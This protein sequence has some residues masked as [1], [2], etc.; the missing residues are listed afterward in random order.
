MLPDLPS[1]KQ[2]IQCILDRYLH[3]AIHER[4]GVFAD[5]PQHAVHEGVEMRIY[6]ADGTV[7]DTDMKEASAEMTLKFEAIPQM[8]IG[9]RISK[10]NELADAMAKQMSEHLYGSLND[11]LEKAG[12]V[13]DGEGKPFGV[14]SV[15][16]ALEKLQVNFDKQGDPTGLQFVVGPALI[17]RIREMMEQEKTDPRIK[18]RHEEILAKKWLE[19]RDREATRKLVG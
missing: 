9:D 12:Q 11:S 3:K 18:A 2:D 17:P 1:L 6:R 13:I 19:W 7:E 14:E 4:L 16:A 15:F 8:T 5:S 10:L